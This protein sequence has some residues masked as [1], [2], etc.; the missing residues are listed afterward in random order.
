MPER[1]APDDKLSITLGD[2][3][4]DVGQAPSETD[5]LY[6]GVLDQS[7]RSQPRADGGEVKTLGRCHASDATG[8]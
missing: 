1:R 6:G 8:L 7:L 4:G 2:Q 5:R 3:V